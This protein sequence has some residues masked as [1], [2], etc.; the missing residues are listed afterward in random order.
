VTDENVIETIHAP[1]DELT[2]LSLNEYQHDKNFHP[3][4]CV[5]QEVL[6][7]TKDGWFCPMCGKIVQTTAL[8][9]STEI[10]KHGEVE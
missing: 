6:V 7:A 3:Y 4:T 8:K 9:S 1:W 2:V 10:I 5:C